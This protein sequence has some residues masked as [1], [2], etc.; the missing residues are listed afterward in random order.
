MHMP[1][2]APVGG[3]LVE[4]Q[5][6]SRPRGKTVG[7]REPVCARDHEANQAEWAVLDP[8]ALELVDQHGARAESR[9]GEEHAVTKLAAE[10]DEVAVAILIDED[11][12]R[13]PLNQV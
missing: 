3:L 1:W 2:K 6:V 7:R 13:C 5:E 8:G 12:D 10:H 9:I 4:D 11:E